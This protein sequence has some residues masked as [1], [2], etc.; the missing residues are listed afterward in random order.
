MSTSFSSSAVFTPIKSARLKLVT[1]SLFVLAAITVLVL[2]RKMVNHLRP[3]NADL[4]AHTAQVSA[5]SEALRRAATQSPTNLADHLAETSGELMRLRGEV[6]RRQHLPETP[7]STP[8]ESTQPPTPEQLREQVK[9]WNDRIEDR[10]N[11]P[12][13]GDSML[14]DAAGKVDGHYLGSTE[15][16]AERMKALEKLPANELER[17][18][19]EAHVNL[20][21]KYELLFR[22]S[23][24]DIASPGTALVFRERKARQIPGGSWLRRY[25]FADGRTLLDASDNGDFSATLGIVWLAVT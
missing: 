24:K 21:D 14:Q 15:A 13:F 25:T 5:R 9:V 7:P 22:G 8:G 12:P 23:F 11:R 6:A 19:K 18:K 2:Q 10:M 20:L 16:I 1:A 3:E 17:L 4:Q